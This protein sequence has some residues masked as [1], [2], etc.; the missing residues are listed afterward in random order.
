M[1]K[2]DKNKFESPDRLNRIVEGT[3]ITGDLIADSSIRIDGE[4][5]GNV[6]TSAKV[7]IGEN[8]LIKG[9]LNCMDADIEGKVEGIL[10]IEALLILREKAKVSGDIIT[11][12]L[13]VEEGA[14][15]VGNCKMSGFKVDGAS[16]PKQQKAEDLVY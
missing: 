8:G 3:K 1:L 10:N 11:G 7:V 16:F 15:F 12:K 4:V 14:Q 2:K 5:E 9:N 13:H 6:S